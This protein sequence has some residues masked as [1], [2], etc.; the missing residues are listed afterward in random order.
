MRPWIRGQAWLLPPSL[1]ELVPDSHPVRFIATFVEQ[2]VPSELGLCLET[3]PR[4]Q[5]EYDPRMLLAAW[6]YGF[7]MRTRTARRLEV[8]ARENLPLIWLLGGQCPDHSTLSRFLA[9]NHAVL[10]RLLKQTVCTAVE[11]GLVA[12]SLPARNG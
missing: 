3:A 5:V 1:D 8:A 9:A 6:I 2:L 10:R 12:C 7:M 4:G 11:V